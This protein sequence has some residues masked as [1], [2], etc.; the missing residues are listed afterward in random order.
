MVEERK[1]AILFAATILCAKKLMPLIAQ[2]AD[3]NDFLTVGLRVGEPRKWAE[4]SAPQGM[5]SS[6]R[7]YKGGMHGFEGAEMFRLLPGIFD[8]IGPL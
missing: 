7:P 1:H 5:R 8:I 2:G 4:G 6:D 3:A